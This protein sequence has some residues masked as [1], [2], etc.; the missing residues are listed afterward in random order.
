MI[1]KL[2]DW[3]KRINRRC[4][5]CNVHFGAHN[6]MRYRSHIGIVCLKCL[7]DYGRY[8]FKGKKK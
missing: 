6:L 2:K 8:E 5:G 1:K 3:Y 4:D 7:K